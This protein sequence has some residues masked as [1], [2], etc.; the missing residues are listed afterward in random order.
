MAKARRIYYTMGQICEMFDLPASTVRYWE[1][2]FKVLSP[3]K[4]AKGNRLFTTSDLENLKL[5]Y[6]LVKEKRMTISGAETFMMQRKVAAKSEMN[7]VEILHR[8]RA[9]LLEIRQ[10]IETAEIK[11]KEQQQDISSTIVVYGEQRDEDVELAE[12][13]FED[14]EDI[15]MERIKKILEDDNS[16]DEEQKEVED[17][18]IIQLTLF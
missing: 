14:S 10:E 12:L 4:N 5:I 1:K 6:H 16:S 8:I 9:R 18:R 17:S 13:S 2:R 11:A 7:M 15:D 3:R